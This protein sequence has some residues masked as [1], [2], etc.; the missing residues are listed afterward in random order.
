M[1]HNCAEQLK[2]HFRSE[3]ARNRTTIPVVAH[4]NEKARSH[5]LALLVIKYTL[6]QFGACRCVDDCG[7]SN[8]A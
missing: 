3:L 6:G 7:L 2:V 5:Q 1:T 8:T 4:E